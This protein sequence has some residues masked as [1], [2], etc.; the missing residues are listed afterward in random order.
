M[1]ASFEDL[2]GSP[3]S[4]EDDFGIVR[5]APV[6]PQ[7]PN[8]LSLQVKAFASVSDALVRS[9]LGK[10]IGVMLARWMTYGCAK[11]HL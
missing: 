9:M 8:E 3:R 6:R 10:A 5:I 11:L 1:T 7:R 2:E 4:P